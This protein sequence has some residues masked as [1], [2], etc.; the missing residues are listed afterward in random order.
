MDP[1]SVLGAASSVVGIAAFGIQLA[2][3][4]NQFVTS[5][6]DANQSLH[7]VL[8]S[9]NA[10][11]LA[12]EQVR[13]LLDEDRKA[14]KKHQ[15][16]TLFNSKALAN[17]KG[18]ADQCLVL[19]WRI[20]ATITNKYERQRDLED[21][22]EEQLLAF[23]ED[24]TAG[25]GPSTPTVNDNLVLNRLQQLKWHFVEPKLEKY[26]RQ[27]QTLQ[28]SLVLMFQV[29]TCGALLKKP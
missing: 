7:D 14:V 15:K 4:L 19:F 23:N 18:L 8:H 2:Q 9:I 20:E 16:A 29:A 24:I 26:S 25:K 6:R 13:S 10:T 21:R 1:V 28:S 12:M 17:I 5:T 22:I 11:S 3:V 27:L